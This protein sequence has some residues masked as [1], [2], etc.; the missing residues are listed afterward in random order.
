MKL[1]L[2]QRLILKVKNHVFVGNR[3]R[4]GWRGSLPFYAFK[5]PMHG[6]QVD[7]PHG[8]NGRLDCPKCSFHV[9]LSSP[10]RK[11]TIYAPNEDFGVHLSRPSSLM[12]MK[13]NNEAAVMGCSYCHMEFVEGEKV[14]VVPPMMRFHKNCYQ[15][16]R[17]KFSLPPRLH[18]SHETIFHVD[19]NRF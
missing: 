10:P 5:C 12:G 16:F 15:L 6:I 11:P 19:V 9:F 8:H 3:N 4:S 14:V 18:V 2:W 13:I 1:S 17:R 7:N